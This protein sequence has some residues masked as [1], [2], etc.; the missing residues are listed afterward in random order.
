MKVLKHTAIALAL[1]LAILVGVYSW[2]GGFSA[3]KVVRQTLPAITVAG[4][5]VEGVGSTVYE[6][7]TEGLTHIRDSLIAR[8][9]DSTLT[10]FNIFYNHNN[11]NPE[12]TVRYITGYILPDSVTSAVQ[13]DS[14]MRVFTLSELNVAAAEIKNRGMLS[15]VLGLN[16]MNLALLAYAENEEL[17]TSV[18][19]LN[20]VEL[21]KGG[22]FG[23][24]LPVEPKPYLF[25]LLYQ[26]VSTP[27]AEDE[28]LPAVPVDSSMQVDS[29]AL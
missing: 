4:F 27:V 9:L 12:D 8:G 29:A 17:D 11:K 24:Y 2:F 19:T 7:G 26:A 16:R 23:Y 5:A 28:S 18:P 10:I 15:L 20:R 3:P 21:Q 14:L 13:S 25:D 6:R 22:T 1:F